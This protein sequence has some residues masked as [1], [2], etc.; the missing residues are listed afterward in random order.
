MRLG[1]VIFEPWEAEESADWTGFGVSDVP[2]IEFSF[3]ILYVISSTMLR[4]LM[5]K[6]NTHHNPAEEQRGAGGLTCTCLRQYR[7]YR[8]GTVQAKD[9]TEKKKLF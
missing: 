8:C 6:K 5:E 1:M 3:I 2:A 7:R 9:T 4:F